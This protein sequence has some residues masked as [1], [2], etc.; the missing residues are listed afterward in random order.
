MKR[1]CAL[2]WVAAALACLTCSRGSAQET[3]PA[4]ASVQEA[5][6]PAN[7]NA[8]APVRLTLQ[9]ALDRAR[10]NSTQF[11]AALTTAA[12]PRQDKTQARNALLPTVT[13]D[14]SL[15]YTQGTPF[16]AQTVIGTPVIFIAN[17]AV[18]EYVSQADIHQV[19]D[20]SAIA[21]F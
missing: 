7:A 19:F 12:L 2:V 17:N 6:K 20:A 1:G 11:Q 10:K 18:H 15:I 13:Y 3:Q 4:P 5:P 9:D 8:P 21:N 16:G 14:N